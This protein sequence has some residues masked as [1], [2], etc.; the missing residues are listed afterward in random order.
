MKK[1]GV[2]YD[3][4]GWLRIDVAFDR[5]LNE[6]I[7]SVF[8]RGNYF[9]SPE[10]KKWYVKQLFRAELIELI[11]NRGYQVETDVVVDSR[12][13]STNPWDVVFERMSEEV[14]NKFYRAAI[15]ALHPDVGGDTEL[16]KEFTQAYRERKDERAKGKRVGAS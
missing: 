11:K 7:K 2:Y 14:A 12:P 6:N 8:G 13:K 10:T 3:D 5:E 9:Y 16:F 15:S 1:A 4:H